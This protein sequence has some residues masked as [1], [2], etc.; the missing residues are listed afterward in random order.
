MHLEPIRCV[1]DWLNDVTNGVNAQIANV[2]LDSG[3]VAPHGV[4]AVLDETRSE[5]LALRHIPES[6]LTPFLFIWMLGDAEVQA[7]NQSK[8]D[9]DSFPI[10]IAYIDRDTNAAN[11]V[12]DG[13]YVMRAVRRSLNR[14]HQGDA[15]GIAA[16]TRNG[17]ETRNG[18]IRMQLL[19]PE[20]PLE[21]AV[22]G[23]CLRATYAV[24]DTSP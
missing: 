6:Q 2:T 11:A 4:V 22:V 12:R 23:V 16:R 10:G 18:N 19:R 3:D 20:L 14:L 5:I 1:A 8:Q 9:I 13:S 15:I 21:N 17:V 7:V 24:R